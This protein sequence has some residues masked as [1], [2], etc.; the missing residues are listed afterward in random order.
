MKCATLIV[1]LFL[2]CSVLS[3]GW[4]QQERPANANQRNA[5][6]TA[7][8]PKAASS[9]SDIQ[10]PAK[11]NT[12]TTGGHLE[13]PTWWNADRGTWALVLVGILGTF[14]AVWTLR[15]LR[16]QLQEM[17]D[18]GRLMDRQATAMEGQLTAM[19][20]QLTAMESSSK[21]TDALIQ[22]ATE[23]AEAIRQQAVLMEGQLKEMQGARTQTERQIEVMRDQVRTM[24]GQ[25]ALQ[26]AAMK[27]WLVLQNWRNERHV[28]P[29]GESV[30]SITFDI[31]NATN[32]PLTL[33][34]TAFQ[35]H[36]RNRQRDIT[37]NH[38]I[39]LAPKEAHSVVISRLSLD[40]KDYLEGGRGATYMLYGFANYLDCFEKEQEMTFS[41]LAWCHKSGTN[42]RPQWA[43]NHPYRKEQR[44]DQETK[45]GEEGKPAEKT[46]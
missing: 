7:E 18:A 39:T 40:D 31:V 27:Q 1:P 23:Q 13:Q 41:G 10:T 26:E 11:N 29:E 2:V 25:L 36:T 20:G 44:T 3:L 38:F 28:N 45:S 17:H 8:E 33:I 37:T 43:P 5:S 30:L 15:I 12:Q 19:Q 24:E 35:I 32:W 21:Q 6:N 4:N 16:G 14:A 9:T 46:N 42:F 34:A 22:R